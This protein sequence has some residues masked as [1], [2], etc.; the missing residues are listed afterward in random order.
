MTRLPGEDPGC[1][2]LEVDQSA[3]P[4]IAALMQ[5]VP[6]E[7][8]DADS[9]SRLLALP[10]VFGLLAVPGGQPAGFV[11]AR[12]A[13]D[14]CEILNVAVAAGSRRQGLGRSLM[15]AAMALAGE[16]GARAMFLEVASDN[17][18]ALA[19]YREL[20]FA[21]AGI[22]PCYYR[23]GP[24]NFTDALIMRCDLITVTGDVP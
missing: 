8:W 24:D 12:L 7:V 11:L 22:R 19:L 17:E 1:G 20:G 15:A 21:Q 5:D 16:R 13:A 3:A 14:E 9:I 23:R 6:G 10:G 4:A 18:P 2:I